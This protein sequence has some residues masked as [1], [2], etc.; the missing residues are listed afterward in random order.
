M[1]WFYAL[2]FLPLSFTIKEIRGNIDRI[3]NTPHPS[4]GKA[5]YKRARTS[6]IGIRKMGF[7]EYK[8]KGDEVYEK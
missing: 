4:C 2:C 1:Y 5:A 6:F 3:E 7:V 8:M